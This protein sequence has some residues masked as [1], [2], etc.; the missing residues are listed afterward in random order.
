MNFEDL[1]QYFVLVVM[2]ACLV[3]GYILKTSF[4]NPRCREELRNMERTI[5]ARMPLAVRVMPV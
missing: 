1:T 5:S 4:D 3:I 2:V